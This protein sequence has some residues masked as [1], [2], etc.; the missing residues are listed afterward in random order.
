MPFSVFAHLLHVGAA[1]FATP[2]LGEILLNKVEEP[3]LLATNMRG[4]F[5]LTRKTTDGVARFGFSPC[6]ADDEPVLLTELA[7]AL[8]ELSTVHEWGIRCRGVPEAVESFQA[9]GLEARTVVVSAQMAQSVLGQDALPPEGLAGNVGKMTVVVT[10]LPENY[11]LVALAPENAGA[12]VR[13]GDNIGMLIRPQAF[14]VVR[15]A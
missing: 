4:K 6:S 8:W 12:C 7:T 14:R 11:A 9:V 5:L 2:A 10:A 15:T 1:G 13:T 3:A